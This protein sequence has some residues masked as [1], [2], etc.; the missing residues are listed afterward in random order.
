MEIR[1]SKFSKDMQAKIIAAFQNDNKID[2]KEALTLGLSKEEAAELS[3]ELAG[4]IQNRGDYA[5]FTQKDKE[6]NKQTLTLYGEKQEGPLKLT[7]DSIAFY[8]KKYP[9]ANIRS[10]YLKNGIVSLL[11]KNGKVAK[12]SAGNDLTV[13]FNKQ[14]PQKNIDLVSFYLNHAGKNFDVNKMIEY[15]ALQDRLNSTPET[16]ESYSHLKFDIEV[17]KLVMMS[18]DERKD[19]ITSK[20]WKAYLNKDFSA[21]ADAIGEFYGY[22]CEQIDD[23][24][25][26]R[27]A[28]DFVK[29]KTRLTALVEYIDKHVDNHSTELS[30]EELIWEVVK[31]VG[32]SID[33]FIGTQGATM[34][35][36][37]GAATKLAT[38]VPKIGGILGGAIQAYFGYDGTKLVGSGL[39]DMAMAETNEQARGAGANIGL[40]AI[41]IHGA[42]KSVDTTVKT[43]EFK[44]FRS[45]LQETTTMEEL[46][47]F[48]DA[49]DSQPYSKEQKQVLKTDCAKQ[50]I[51]IEEYRKANK[52][53]KNE[54]KGEPTTSNSS[55]QPVAEGQEREGSVEP[56]P[57]SE[58]SEQK[59]Y[60]DLT[61]LSTPE[62]RVGYAKSQG[63]KESSITPAEAEAMYKK[64]GFTD[65][66]IEEV[67]KANPDADKWMQTFEIFSEI[68]ESDSN[69]DNMSVAEIKEEIIDMVDEKQADQRLFV[70]INEEN[71]KWAQENFRSPDRMSAIKDLFQFLDELEDSKADFPEQY[72][73]AKLAQDL[74]GESFAK[75]MD[76]AGNI[77]SEEQLASFTPERIAAA[78]K[79]SDTLGREFELFDARDIENPELITPE[80]L[81]EYKSAKE[82]LEAMNITFD[83]GMQN[84]VNYLTDVKKVIEL[85]KKEGLDFTWYQGKEGDTS[86][87]GY[88]VNKILDNSQK[89]HSIKVFLDMC[90]PEA[91]AKYSYDIVT[92]AFEVGA[93]NPQGVAK[94]F[95]Q[96]AEFVYQGNKYDPKNFINT[97]SDYGRKENINWQGVANL[98][99]VYVKN[100]LLFE[101]EG[102]MVV[103]NGDYNG[104]VKLINELKTFF[105]KEEGNKI[106]S[107][108]GGLIEDRYMSFL[109][110]CWSKIIRN[111]NVDFNEATGRVKQLEEKF[112]PSD[113]GD[114]ETF[115]QILTSEDNG[116]VEKFETV[117][118]KGLK[119]N[120]SKTIEYISNPEATPEDFK[121][122][123]E[124]RN[125]LYSIESAENGEAIADSNSLLTNKQLSD[126]FN[127]IGNKLSPKEKVWLMS[128]F[129]KTNRI[130]GQYASFHARALEII[131]RM[132]REDFDAE[133][134]S[135]IAKSLNEINIDLVDK[136]IFNEETRLPRN[137]ASK[138]LSSIHNAEGRRLAEILCFDKE[139]NC[140]REY[141]EYIV[142]RVR[143]ENFELAKKLCLDKTFPDEFIGDI[144]TEAS[145][146]KV[147][148][149]ERLCA[150]KDFPQ[151]YI[152][153]ILSR[154]KYKQFNGH[155]M[156]LAE[157]L[158][159]DK[160]LNFP[161]ERIADILDYTND[162]NKDLITR[163]CTDTN[164]NFPIKYITDV[165]HSLRAEKGKKVLDFAEKLC[166]DKELRFPQ[167]KIASLISALDSNK[168]E[169]IEKMIYTKDFSPENLIKLANSLISDAKID[170]AEQ[171]YNT[172]EIRRWAD[173]N[174]DN[175]DVET[176]INLARTQKKLFAEAKS[177]NE[178]LEIQIRKDTARQIQLEHQAAEIKADPMALDKI[179]S[180]LIDI[181][182]PEGMA[183]NAYAKLCVNSNGNVDYTKLEAAKSLIKAYGFYTRVNKK[184]QTA[185][186]PNLTP[187][188][189]TDIFKLATG[190]KMSAE[191]GE[192]RPQ[193][194]QDIITLKECGVDDIKFAMNLASVKNMSLIE[195]KARFKGETRQDIAKRIDEGVNNEIKQTLKSRGIDLDAVK[196]K[197]LT[198]DKKIEEM[199]IKEGHGKTGNIRT[200]ES[201]VG[202][203]KVVLNK[204][205][206]ELDPSVW[207]DEAA[208]K[209]W[210]EEKLA[211]ITDWEKHPEYNAKGRFD[212]Y[213]QPRK[214]AF[215]KWIEYLNS[216]ECNVRD[217]V[218]SKI[219]FLEGLTSEMKPDNAYTPPAI[220]HE[221]FE[222]AYNQLLEGNTTV[223]LTKAYA[224][225]NRTKAIQKYGEETTS[226]DGV[227]G[228]WVKIPSGGKR[229]EPLYDEHI[230]MIQALSEGSS[231]CLRFENAHTYLGYGD[232]HFF[233]TKQPDGSFVSQTAI[234]V[235]P[236]GKIREIEKRYNQDRTVPVPYVQVIKEWKEANKFTGMDYQIQ[237]ALDAKPEFDRQKAEF[238]EMQK[239][240]D[241]KGIFNALGIEVG[242]YEGGGYYIQSKNAQTYSAFVNGKPYTL[243]DLGVNENLLMKDVVQVIGDINLN[244]S[245]LTTTPRLKQVS[246]RIN[247]GDNKIGDL[248]S[249]ETI[250]GKQVYWEKPEVKTPSE[251][252]K[253]SNQYNEKESQRTSREDMMK[254][255]AE[256]DAAYKTEKAAENGEEYEAPT[257]E[258]IQQRRLPDFTE[259]EDFYDDLMDRLNQID[260]SVIDISDFNKSASVINNKHLKTIAE[261]ICKNNQL[262]KSLMDYIRDIDAGL[263]NI[264]DKKLAKYLRDELKKL[265]QAE[266]EPD[267]YDGGDYN[268]S[269]FFRALGDI[270]Q[271][272]DVYNTLNGN[273]SRYQSIE[274]LGADIYSEASRPAS[275]MKHERMFAFLMSLDGNVEKTP[276]IKDF[277]S[278]QKTE[279]LE[280]L[281]NK[282]EMLD[283]MY[284]KFYISKVEDPKVRKLCRD[285]NRK[286][287]VRVLLSAQTRN[288]QK[289]LKVI[290]NELESWTQLSEGKA[291]LPIILDLNSCDIAYREAAAYTDIRGN[292]HN[293][294]AK[295]HSS[296]IIR[297]EIMHLNEPNLSA[298][299]S[300]SKDY[301][302]FIRSIIPS[303]T[304]EKGGI[305]KE[306]LDWENCKFREEFLKAGIEPEHVEYAYTNRNEFLSVAAEGDLTQY[307]PEFRQVLIKIGMP[308]YVFDLPLNDFKTECNVDRV[309]AIL[310]EH[311]DAKFD[312]LV[313]YIEEKR[314]EVERNAAALFDHL[315]GKKD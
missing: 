197:A 223:S 120:Y 156:D 129:S 297:H 171:A 95:N 132:V 58:L 105:D 203:E 277:E 215:E 103:A 41:M 216:E 163:L 126:L 282:T 139:F 275:Y 187:K 91:K 264:T 158:C 295:I 211:D 212:A 162:N 221:A 257:W 256:W 175:F 123:L 234:N 308:E 302:E 26:V 261:T 72:R 81:K 114:Y 269:N 293:N 263:E 32:D 148:F 55:K 239:N 219:L 176:V 51:K 140:E 245:A 85:I 21:W 284:E 238:A 192:F 309:K 185:V 76:D 97:I 174:L 240:G 7:P 102:Y 198:S 231:W 270:G 177:A 99:E 44:Q 213:N 69:L 75:L 37:F 130:G 30:G 152:S 119:A 47:E 108:N 206:A 229:G 258:E 104:A 301:A 242:D 204:Y 235:L 182:V 207:Q 35:M 271:L 66:D 74:T 265:S 315:F 5:E 144:L 125:Q 134:L 77:W 28:K 201:I 101:P 169:F 306:V 274:L 180:V 116:I 131:E 228:I 181:G 133:D 150:E 294:G 178:T 159:F 145:T 291:R 40:G 12:D 157:T 237:Q 100:D 251:V 39:I 3:R 50:Y 310:K 266:Y 193:I 63:L 267:R 20:M 149:A 92:L 4:N 107:E 220:S 186:N 52:E 48:V 79:I 135:R 80:F 268:E 138:I 164:L 225:F 83:S 168:A 57:L 88:I 252:R 64:R 112:L 46:N 61:V 218:F 286:Y 179:S 241:V 166:T 296:R 34:I 16:E 255:I 115:K 33:S 22:E 232:L 78:K 121:K 45:K 15:Q 189:I 153:I 25:K 170:E 210:A 262:S 249:L 8:T 127:K 298:T 18:Y 113:I 217:D 195:M 289:A 136:L 214:E 93:K 165:A 67:R 96:L 290:Q 205:K 300:S 43:L 124:L 281:S 86:V 260:Y 155:N 122:N 243:F 29:D 246:G 280:Q 82:Q 62:G 202:T 1:L 53:V 307:S 244:G 84:P 89:L 143:P 14:V 248:R 118:K 311:P 128:A 194:I 196:E 142:N 117:S 36:G 259:R 147:E 68:K 254:K 60:E 209:R 191:N 183:K 285:I 65:A 146:N 200:L 10:A 288:I 247:F 224:Q 70:F 199:S 236:D 73:I 304:I 94:I 151:I 233:L 253:E 17:Q 137:I 42:K 161:K 272:V 314:K 299:Y 184:G 167:D 303:K 11:D 98:L 190:D 222:T 273:Y 154:L 2:D 188:D 227:T 24:L 31:G 27:A 173:K 19:Y 111:E 279:A 87:P 106:G 276:R 59:P 109:L 110:N 172:P 305:K 54:V 283:Y 312:E 313:K 292:I 6:G 38:S 287:G 9:D 49:I 71:L 208:F 141:I 56:A 226:E 13:D 90:S 230:A 278:M 250:N 23:A 160:E